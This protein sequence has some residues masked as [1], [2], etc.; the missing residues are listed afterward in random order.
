MAFEI[1]LNKTFIKTKKI[2]KILII[3]QKFNFL[4]LFLILQI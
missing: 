2:R 4:L 1:K 3:F